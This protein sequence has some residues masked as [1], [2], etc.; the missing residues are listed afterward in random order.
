MGKSDARIEAGIRGA[1]SVEGVTIAGSRYLA[2]VGWELQILID[3]GADSHFIT[4]T[5]RWVVKVD[6]A[7][8][9]GQIAVVPASDGVSVTFQ[10]QN[11]NIGTSFGPLGS[12]KLCLDS[13]FRSSSFDDDPVG[14]A[15]K[16]IEW[17]LLRAKEWVT[18]AANETLVQHGDFFEIPR[19]VSHESLRVIHDD[20]ANNLS[21]W[22][23]HMAE[24][25]YVEFCPTFIGRTL[26]ATK[27]RDR[28]RTTIRDSLLFPHR[29]GRKSI[30]GM[31]WLW[32]KPIVVPPW[33]AAF[34]WGQLRTIGAQQGIAVDVLLEEFAHAARSRQQINLIMLGYPI[35]LRVG[36][37][38][39]EI[40][41]ETIRI[42]KLQVG[43]P[44]GFRPSQRNL[45]ELDRKVTFADRQRLAY[46]PTENWSAERL[47]ARGR[48]PDAVRAKQVTIIGCGALG[49][50]V[51][52]LLVRAGVQRLRLIDGETLVA[53]NMVRHVLTFA[54][55]GAKKSGALAKRLRECSPSTKIEAVEHHLPSDSKLVHDRLEE[56][57]LVVDC[58]ASD[59]VLQTMGAVYWSI[60][61][62]FVSASLGF[63]AQRLFLFRSQGNRFDVSE[64]RKLIEPWSKQEDNLWSSAKESREGAGCYSPLFPARVDD[65]MAAAVAVVKFI[66][67]T[68]ARNDLVPQMVVLQSSQYGGFSQIE[69]PTD[70]HVQAA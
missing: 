13:P 63:A 43:P 10:H 37:P 21:D 50:M 2:G 44:K 65:V 34:T 38:D 5:T 19:V 8:P 1:R 47:Q 9:R 48:L 4:R 58:T 7:Y 6:L 39:Q 15:D 69:K 32:P 12:G 40:H 54:D 26:L 17:H 35:P 42:P 67:E 33:Q 18:R 28:N 11:P 16:R 53:G 25:G 36:A 61:R 46:M 20:T 68:L 27:F 51:A 59:E 29:I 30:E 41:W 49:S 45:W 31:W 60:P 66:E 23:P 55:L 56:A 22:L 62:W 64:F 70:E 57:D 52:E 14:D 24:S 3:A